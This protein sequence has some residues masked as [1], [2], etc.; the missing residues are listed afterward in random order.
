MF[1]VSQTKIGHQKRV[2]GERYNQ[3]ERM[4]CCGHG[5]GA[6]SQLRQRGDR[7]NVVRRLEDAGGHILYILN[8]MKNDKK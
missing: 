4:L 3:G 2:A 1:L 5:Q 8:G 6:Q 7:S